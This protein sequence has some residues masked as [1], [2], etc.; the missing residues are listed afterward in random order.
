LTVELKDDTKETSY[1]AI[2]LATYSNSKPTVLSYVT[3]FDTLWKQV[4]LYIEFLTRIICIN[5]I[6][7][8]MQKQF[9]TNR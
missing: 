3:I 5:Q 4:I 7:N 9:L 8:K 1:E 2:G 6:H